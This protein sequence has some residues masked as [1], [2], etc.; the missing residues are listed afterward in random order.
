[1]CVTC[2]SVVDTGSFFFTFGQ[3]VLLI[4][5]QLGG[6]GIM[7]FTSLALY[8]MGRHVPLSDRIS[9]QQSLLLDPR[10]SSRRFLLRVVFMTFA[11]ELIGAVLLW[12]KETRR[13][14]VQFRTQSGCGLDRWRYSCHPR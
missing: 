14:T 11:I 4:L 2:L 1:M 7:T 13:I 8:L 5:I 10:F 12:I 9:I 3:A 6:L